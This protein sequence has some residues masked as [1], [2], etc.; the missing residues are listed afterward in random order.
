MRSGDPH[1]SRCVVCLRRS[2]P[3]RQSTRSSSD[4]NRSSS[5]THGLVARLSY[6]PYGN[7]RACH[8]GLSSRSRYS[9]HRK[10]GR[11]RNYSRKRA[12]L[13]GR[14]CPSPIHPHQWSSGHSEKLRRRNRRNTDRSS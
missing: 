2:A 8:S 1:C 13:S 14:S 12:F 6:G 4:N 9:G 11:A 5:G 7:S 3:S 10:R